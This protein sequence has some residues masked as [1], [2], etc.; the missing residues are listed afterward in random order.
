MEF[1]NE[2][3][4]W[5]KTER[6]RVHNTHN[7]TMKYISILKMLVLFCVNNNWL[8]KDPFARFKISKLEV[9][10]FFLTKEELE[11]LSSKEIM[12]ERLR[13]IRAEFLFSC[14]TGFSYVDIHKL[15]ASEISVDVDNQV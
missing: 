13:Q 3:E 10:R 7:T 12:L 11:A 8:D 5:L 1:V 6:K 15:K 9:I 4:L 14:F 2:L